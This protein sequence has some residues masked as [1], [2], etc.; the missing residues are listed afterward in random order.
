MGL[1]GDT[2][3]AALE[4]LRRAGVQTG[5]VCPPPSLSQQ[6]SSFYTELFLL[7]KASKIEPKQWPKATTV[8]K[9][10][11][12]VPCP[13]VAA[14]EAAKNWLNQLPTA[15]LLQ[16]E[17]ESPAQHSSFTGLLHQQPC[18]T[19]HQ[20][21]PCVKPLRLVLTFAGAESIC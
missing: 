19:S 21:C 7:E 17:K 4:V 20:V 12:Q 3:P 5:Q 9:L 16:G 10:C 1:Q 8:T 6:L 11:A 13:H 18:Y 14:G 2:A 15:S